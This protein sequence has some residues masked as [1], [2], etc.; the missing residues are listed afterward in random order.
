MGTAGY[1]KHQESL[2]HPTAE[3]ILGL[4]WDLCFG[5]RGAPGDKRIQEQL[6]DR[7]CVGAQ[8]LEDS[9]CI[10]ISIFFPQMG[11]HLDQPERTGWSEEC[12][13]CSHV[14][15][16]VDLCGWTGMCVYI[17][18]LYTCICVHAYREQT[19]S[20]AT[21]RSWAPG[22]VAASSPRGCQIRQP[23]WPCTDIS[24]YVVLQI[25]KT[26]DQLWSKSTIHR[27]VIES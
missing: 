27:E 8:L 21:G 13:L 14:S 22:A 11:L 18:V 25:L 2:I 5:V 10:Y 1:R 7:L 24:T 20:L 23:L 9:H 17:S 19:P 3:E 26:L 16:C 6:P 15:A 12:H 4:G